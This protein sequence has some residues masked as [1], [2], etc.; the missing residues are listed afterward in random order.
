[1]RIVNQNRKYS[2]LDVR[3]E[4]LAAQLTLI[5]LALFKLITRDE[6]L[7]LEC[8]GSKSK[9]KKEQLLPNVIAMNRQFNQV[10]YWVVSQIL[11]HQ[12]PRTRAEL[13]SHFIRTAKRLH[14]L[15]NLHSS[16][17]CIS[18]LLSSPIYR[19]D[20]TWY[21]VRKKYPKEKQTLDE[22]VEFYSDERNYEQLRNHLLNCSLPCIPYL[23][24]YSRDMIYIKEAYREG[25]EQ[26]KNSIQKIL[27]S[28]SR[29]QASEYDNL[30]Y[31]TE[32]STVLLS[33]RYIDELQ[34]FVEDDTY[35]RSLELEPPD[36][37]S[38]VA[39]EY[40]HSHCIYS[41]DSSNE[42][43]PVQ[44]K[45]RKSAHLFASLTSI[46]QSAVIN[47]SN[48]FGNCSPRRSSN[49]PQKDHIYL[50]DDSFIDHTILPPISTSS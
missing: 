44:P 5:D 45:H 38:N 29:F 35:R 21:F 47:T 46:V 49:E 18:A 19:L 20:R 23:G 13:I 24:L 40:N 39:T 30:N 7:N 14:Q 34:R 12:L 48:R 50:I 31:I 9:P 33:N 22:L 26:R 32:L 4:D 41:N 1:M 28:I 27:D 37:L 10:T 17:A 36:P 11:H 25:S 6:I 15:N 2:S 3:I 43:D 42:S 16:F 8:S